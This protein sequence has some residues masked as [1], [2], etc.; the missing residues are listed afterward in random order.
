MIFGN[1]GVEAD[2]ILLVARAV[3]DFED[4]AGA[5]GFM[6]GGTDQAAV[7]GDGL[8]HDRRVADR[9]K[10][11]ALKHMHQGQRTIG[12]AHCNGGTGG[13][14][15]NRRDQRDLIPNLEHLLDFQRRKAPE[16]LSP[17]V[18]RVKALPEV[19]KDRF[20]VLR[21]HIHGSQGQ[22]AYGGI[23]EAAPSGR[24][25]IEK[26]IGVPS[27]CVIRRR[28]LQRFV[29]ERSQS[30]PLL[31]IGRFAKSPAK[32]TRFRKPNLRQK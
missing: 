21:L 30:Y 17:I 14:R 31:L 10:P 29:R 25:L 16:A 27:H 26:N 28:T 22:P 1:I 11:L 12:F 13:F 18:K 23:Q 9:H 8:E 19:T 7:L 24:A 20:N 5:D 15:G 32:P 3:G 2:L 4:A 6:N